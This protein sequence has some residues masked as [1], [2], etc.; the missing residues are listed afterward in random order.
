MDPPGSHGSHSLEYY[1]GSR[2]EKDMFF[3]AIVMLRCASCDVIVQPTFSQAA[4]MR[5]V[6]RR[7]LARMRQDVEGLDPVRASGPQP[8]R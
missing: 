8:M 2:D 4:E 6:L 3:G 7:A 5:I 1:I